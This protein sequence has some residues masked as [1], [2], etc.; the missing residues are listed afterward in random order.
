[1]KVKYLTTTTIT[2][3]YLFSVFVLTESRTYIL[4]YDNSFDGIFPQITDYDFKLYKYKDIDTK[5]NS[6]YVG[7][8]TGGA[9]SMVDPP[10]WKVP[11]STERVFNGYVTKFTM[12]YYC[13]QDDILTYMISSCPDIVSYIECTETGWTYNHT[14][15]LGKCLLTTKT[16]NF[17]IWALGQVP[18][19]IDELRFEITEEPET[20]TT[21]PT[22]T[23]SPVTTP[24]T[25]TPPKTIPSVTTPPT[26][27]PPK[28]TPSV[29]T[30]HTTTPPKTTPSVTTPPKTTPPK[31][32]PPTTPS[33]TTSPT[34]AVPTTPTT[35]WPTT[36]AP[37]T[38]PTTEAPTTV[39]P[40]TEAPTTEAPRTSAPKGFQLEMFLLL[41]SSDSTWALIVI[42]FLVLLIFA[43]KRRPSNVLRV[44]NYI[45]VPRLRTY[46]QY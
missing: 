32:T 21:A 28:T 42:I 26:T 8:N 6:T 9:F 45:D 20:T 1:M 16:F 27:T 43:L 38:P 17:T 40:T 35:T 5:L 12:S 18:L 29:T 2:I 34:T 39:A 10:R 24:P 36:T 3:C 22:T 25:T 19:G 23:T 46:N 14:I 33:V 30:P 4:N 13:T 11:C 44:N 37:T 7:P 31:T 15:D 41:R